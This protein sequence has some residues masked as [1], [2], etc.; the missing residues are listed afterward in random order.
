MCT[1]RV[2]IARTFP[3]WK[4]RRSLGRR[5]VAAPANQQTTTPPT[6]NPKRSARAEWM[7]WW[8]GWPSRGGAFP[9]RSAWGL[10]V[11][12]FDL[13]DMTRH[14]RTA[15][16]TEQTRT[17]Q[18]RTEQSVCMHL[19]AEV[20]HCTSSPKWGC[21]RSSVWG[22]VGPPELIACGGWPF[23]EFSKVRELVV[24]WWGEGGPPHLPFF[25]CCM[26][27]LISLSLSLALLFIPR[28]R[29]SGICSGR[30]SLLGSGTTLKK[31][32]RR[33]GR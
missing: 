23:Q 21:W 3:E 13:T 28:G 17:E 9:L 24:T 30:V 7:E 18:N 29:R 32:T 1:W 5:R 27:L 8:K 25:F 22:R 33:R 15:D 14:D 19:H 11:V 20:G 2:S 16:R 12:R 4:C 26:S 31:A 10:G 6:P